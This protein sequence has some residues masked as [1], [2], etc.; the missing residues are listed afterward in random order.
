MSHSQRSF[1][2]PQQKT[3]PN[4]CCISQINS[5][6]DTVANYPLPQLAQ[7]LCECV[8]QP[9]SLPTVFQALTQAWNVGMKQKLEDKWELLQWLI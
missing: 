1:L 8:G 3:V 6:H 2:N 9:V 4:H 5:S 7:K